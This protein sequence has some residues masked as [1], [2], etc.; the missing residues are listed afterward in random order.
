VFFKLQLV[1]FF[2]DLRS[3]RQ[4]MDVAADRL[5]IRWFLGYDLNE[6]FPDHSSLTRIRERYGLE[7][8]RRFFERIVE[9]CVEVGPVRGDELFFDATKVRANA[10]VD[11]LCSRSLVENHLDELFEEQDRVPD[12]A[13]HDALG[14][15]VD[16][17]LPT[18]GDYELAAAN[19][20]RGDWISRAGHQDC[21]FK[22]GS[23]RR[24]SDLMV[25]RT[26]P[27]ATPMRRC[28]SSNN[29][30]TIYRNRD[31][32]Y[33]DRVRAYRWTFS[34]EKTRARRH[35]LLSHGNRR[36]P[37]HR[38]KPSW[39]PMKVFLNGLDPL[40][41]RRAGHRTGRPRVAPGNRLLV[42]SQ[43]PWTL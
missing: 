25:S 27:D 8:F 7:V 31:E 26:D 17:A 28:T 19:V 33:Y 23:R 29:G 32:D 34:Y 13:A 4:L 43:E 35:L 15:V 37:K 9:M 22:S 5:S 12:T 1:L 39:R 24:T 6:S 10:D 18:A 42:V 40:C 16:R 41:D 11:S 2:E 38:A 14:A 21:F 20:R 30:R 36:M 3:E